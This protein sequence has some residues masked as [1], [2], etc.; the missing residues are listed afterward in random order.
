M[1]RVEKRKGNERRGQVKKIRQIENK[2][3]IGKRE[4]K[5]KE[6]RVENWRGEATF[7]LSAFCSET[8]VTE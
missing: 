2:Q 8:C 1:R 3:E 4:R 6:R 5:G 7:E